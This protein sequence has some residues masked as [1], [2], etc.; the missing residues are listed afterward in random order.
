MRAGKRKT[1]EVNTDYRIDT[2]TVPYEVI[3][4]ATINLLVHRNWGATNLT[5]SVAIYDDR[6][7]FSNPGTFPNGTS[8]E[9]FLKDDSRSMPRNPTI[10]GVFYKRG[11]MEKWGRGIELIFK[12]CEAVGLPQPEY[13]SDKYFVDLIIRFKKPLNAVAEKV[14]EKFSKQI[15]QS[16]IQILEIV[17][18][19]PTIKADDIASVMHVSTRT[20][21]SRL[22]DLQDIGVLR[23]EGGAKG[24]RWEVI[25]D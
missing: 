2:L 18:E 13:R 6:M 16:M 7:V 19:T 12:E 4:E 3:K 5:P 1:S 10:A 23:R 22:K 8:W 21:S 17:Q 15:S 9:Y 24:G 25:N 11:I 14:A 20:V